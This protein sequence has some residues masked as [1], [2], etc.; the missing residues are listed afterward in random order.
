VTLDTWTRGAHTADGTTHPTYRNGTRPRVE[1]GGRA[2]VRQVAVLLDAF[3]AVRF[4][5]EGDS[6]VTEHRQQEAV[7]RILAFLHERLGSHPAG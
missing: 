7:D 3:I 4:E 5:G 1:A 6:A 2:N